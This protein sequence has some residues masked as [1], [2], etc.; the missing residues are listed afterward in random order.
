MLTLGY[1][2]DT[3]FCVLFESDKGW[4]E[5]SVKEGSMT[6]TASHKRQI[7]ALPSH[8][9]DPTGFCPGARVVLHDF[10]HRPVVFKDDCWTNPS[11]LNGTS[12]TIIRRE[13]AMW[14]VELDNDLSVRSTPS[15]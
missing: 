4:Q 7:S 1:V 10:N 2:A 13:K 15:R 12:G 5:F 14:I 8:Q 6:V 11:L 9:N 3:N